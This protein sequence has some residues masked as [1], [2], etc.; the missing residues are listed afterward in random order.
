M[1]R[2]TVLVCGMALAAGCSGIA[3]DNDDAPDFLDAS[4]EIEIRIDGEEFDLSADR[5]QSEHA[6]DHA[7]EFHLHEFDELWY[8]EGQ[9][10]VTFG[11]GLDLLPHIEYRRVDGSH[12][13]KIDDDEY[14]ERDGAEIEFSVNGES[15]DPT[16][17]ELYD[18]DSIRV[19]IRT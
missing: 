10:R 19:T 12:V 17:Y 13:L 11:E 3:S 15:V 7:L 2:R 9:E 1:K 18:G 16:E 14:D 6:D 4:G 5:F 8:M